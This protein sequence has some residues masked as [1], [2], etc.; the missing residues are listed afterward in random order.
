MKGDILIQNVSGREKNGSFH[1]TVFQIEKD[2][3]SEQK[4]EVI[5]T[6]VCEASKKFFTT[7]S[8]S[9]EFKSK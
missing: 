7:S 1:L 9:D 5:A 3:V 4:E 6:Q 8:K 2:N